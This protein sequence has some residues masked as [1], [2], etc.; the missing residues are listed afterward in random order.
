MPTALYQVHP[1][2]SEVVYEGMR[3]AATGCVEAINACQ[4]DDAKC[5]ACPAV[6]QSPLIQTGPVR[7]GTA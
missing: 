3:L 1:L 7:S 2:V 6:L 4:A 5:G